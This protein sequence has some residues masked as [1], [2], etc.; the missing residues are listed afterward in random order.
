M[1]RSAGC[2]LFLNGP[3]TVTG[4][5]SPPFDWVQLLPANSPSSSFYGDMVYDEARGVSLA[6]GS[7]GSWFRHGHSMGRTGP[8]TASEFSA[9]S[10]LSSA[11]L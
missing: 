8:E 4:H 11:R 3:Q 9:I 2:F 1:H 5:F 10:W 7:D 6:F